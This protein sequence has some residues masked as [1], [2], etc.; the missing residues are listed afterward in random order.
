MHSFDLQA[1]FEKIS[2]FEEKLRAERSAALYPNFMAA[3]WRE[4]Y[5]REKRRQKEQEWSEGVYANGKE[6]GEVK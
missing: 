4:V 5:D 6:E 1:Q 2:R 3:K